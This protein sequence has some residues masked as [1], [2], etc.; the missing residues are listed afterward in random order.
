LVS[1]EGEGGVFHLGILVYI[2]RKGTLLTLRRWRLT[3]AY[4]KESFSLRYEHNTA[5]GHLIKLRRSADI[6]IDEN[7]GNQEKSWSSWIGVIIGAG[8]V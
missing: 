6:Q 5:K 1:D 3:S 7:V 8:I 2:R 4:N